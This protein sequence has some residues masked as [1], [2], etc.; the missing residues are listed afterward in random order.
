MKNLIFILTI[1]LAI[2]ACQ[3]TKAQ[4]DSGKKATDAVLNS[5]TAAEKAEGW[6]L[7][8]DGKTT[9]QWRGYGKADFLKGWIIDDN[10]IRCLGS[11]KG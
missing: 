6:T 8:F 10:S 5:L 9:D 7:L 2:S 11:G 3:S 4:V 1:V